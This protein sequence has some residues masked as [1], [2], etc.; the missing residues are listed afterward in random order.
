V[1][2]RPFSSYGWAA[3]I[4]WLFCILLALILQPD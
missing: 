4:A 3:I 1:E 2:S